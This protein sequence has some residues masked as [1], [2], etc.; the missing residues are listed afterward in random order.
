MILLRCC[1]PASAHGASGAAYA[2][3]RGASGADYA[4][5]G[6]LPFVATGFSLWHQ[7]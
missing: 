6:F 7:R 5:L 2:R 3:L 4:R 1:Q